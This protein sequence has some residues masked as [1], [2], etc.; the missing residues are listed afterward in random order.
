MWLV[1]IPSD[2]ASTLTPDLMHVALRR[3]LRLPLP[4][5]GR[6][7]GA[8]GRHGCGAEVD[9]YGDHRFACPR[10]GLLPRRG[11]VVERAWVQVAREAVGPEGRVVPQQWLAHTTAPQGDDHWGG[12]VLR[13]DTR[14]PPLTRSGRPVHGADVRARGCRPGRGPPAQSRTLPGTHALRSDDEPL[15]SGA[16][17]TTSASNPAPASRP[18]RPTPLSRVCG[19]G[20]GPPLVE[21]LV[22]RAL[23]VWSMP[24]LPG[25]QDALPLVNV[26]DFV[27]R[28]RAHPVS[29]RFA[30]APSVGRELPE[31]LPY[32]AGVRR[33]A[34]QK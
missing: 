20:L 30:N 2:A 16:A 12:L 19:T 17:G 18:A 26:L 33:S 34:G 28:V 7:C 11:F 14:V 21:R 31:D 32:H 29:C 22:R 23:G 25:A 15:R 1:A 8:Q 24:P 3:R 5:T 4:L 10:I 13:C 9:A 6:R 27:P